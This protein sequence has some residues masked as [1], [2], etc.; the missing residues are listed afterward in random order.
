[1]ETE[2]CRLF[3]PLI[4]IRYRTYLATQS[5]L[6]EDH[7]ILRD[8]DIHI[9][10]NQRHDDGQVHGRLGDA[11]SA[12]DIDIGIVLPDLEIQALLDD[13]DQ[14]VQTIIIDAVR[15]TTRQ[16]KGAR[17][18]QA[19]NLDQQRTRPLHATADDRTAGTDRS[20]G[21]QKLRRVQHLMQPGAI[22][23]EHRDLVRRAETVLL[24]MQDAEAASGLALEKEDDVDHMLEDLRT[25]DRTVLRH[26][27]DEEDCDP[28]L[29]RGA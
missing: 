20:S 24:P 21:E 4:G 2:A 26:M 25:G 27:T 15:R 11:Q 8:L 3:D 16:I 28:A 13:G 18:E 22:H 29:L 12:G 23:L 19:L 6:T 14:Q 9:G 5:D 1:M 17:Y 10:R 7:H